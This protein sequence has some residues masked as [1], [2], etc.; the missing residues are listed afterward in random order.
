MTITDGAVCCIQYCILYSL[1]VLQRAGSLHQFSVDVAVHLGLPYVVSHK[2]NF[3]NLLNSRLF[4]Q[5]SFF[6]NVW[7][8]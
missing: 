2:R 5:L 8:N 3:R 6:R 1:H 7:R 4:L